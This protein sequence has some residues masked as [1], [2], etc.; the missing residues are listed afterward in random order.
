MSVKK[1]ALTNEEMNSAAGG[2]VEEHIIGVME[3]YDRKTGEPTGFAQPGYWV[4][5]NG[6]NKPIACYYLPEYAVAADAEYH[7]DGTVLQENK[8]PDYIA[9]FEESTPI[10]DLLK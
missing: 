3:S 9:V 2:R 5:D 4:F 7:R 10:Q 8:I 6:T 1:R